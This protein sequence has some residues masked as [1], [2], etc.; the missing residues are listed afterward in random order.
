VAEVVIN[1]Y[2]NVYNE[3]E[4]NKKFILG[5]LDKEEEKFKKTLEKGLKEFDKGTDAFILFSTYGFPI[6]MTQELAKEKGV[7]ID[8]EKFN[9]QMK[10]HQKLSRTASVGKFKSGLA[11][12]SEETIKLHTA[13]HLLL[14]ALRKVLGDHVI[15]R[16]SNITAKRLRFDFSH[17]EKMTDEQKQEVEKLVN[18]VIEKDLEVTMEEMTVEEAKKQGAMGVFES[19]YGQKVKVYTVEDP[20]VNSGQVFSK[21]ICAGPHVERT[22]QLGYFKIIKEQ[23]S[24]AGVRRIKAVLE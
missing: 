22:G 4:R 16:G 8:I 13:A 7:K 21:E 23:S 24:S 5:Q 2:S 19:K 3:L 17:S 10:K 20:S 1:D 9:K 12:T 14:A 11:D 15:Q 6:E 18:E